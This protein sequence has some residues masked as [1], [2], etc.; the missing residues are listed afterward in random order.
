MAVKKTE[1]LS[2]EEALK[3]LEETVKA[4]ES[5]TVPLEESLKLFE[6][7]VALVK[8]C[9]GK[10]DEAEQ[11]VRILRKTEDGGIVEEDMD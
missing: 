1:D 4:L 2:F 6:E 5:G 3:R 7:G 9:N 11:K 10:L 8:L